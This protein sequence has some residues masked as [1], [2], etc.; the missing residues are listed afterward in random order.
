MMSMVTIIMKFAPLGV[1]CLIAKTFATQGIDMIIPLASIFYRHN[2][3][4][5]T[6]FANIFHF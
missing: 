6:C 2:S 4:N 5:I 1:F 3:F